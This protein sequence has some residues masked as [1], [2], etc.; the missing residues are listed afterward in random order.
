MA[1]R[2]GAEFLEGL[3][4]RKREVWLGDERVDDVTA[5]PQ[6]AGAAQALAAVFDLQHDYP[7]DCLMPDP[8]TGEPINVSHMIPRSI[9]DLKRRHR[10]LA[11]HRRDLGRAS[12]VARPTT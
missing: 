1:A 11:T 5:H 2:T 10:G 8:E 7:D 4:N 12:W 6:L 9:D 3:R